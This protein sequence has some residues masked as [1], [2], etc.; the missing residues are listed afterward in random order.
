MNGN[1][2]G[3]LI[4]TVAL[5]ILWLGITGKFDCF[6]GTFNC[7]LGRADGAS[8]GAAPQGSAKQTSSLGT[9]GLKRLE[10]R[11]GASNSV[12]SPVFA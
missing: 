12:F 2:S 4:V 6:T 11:V 8:G 3:L 5:L 7:M 1:S 10:G 9:E